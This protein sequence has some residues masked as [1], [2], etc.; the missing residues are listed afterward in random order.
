MK[1]FEST[2]EFKKSF[3][4]TTSLGAARLKSGYVKLEKLRNEKR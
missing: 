3:F 1:T 2:Q 4:Q